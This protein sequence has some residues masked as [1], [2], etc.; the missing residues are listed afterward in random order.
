MELLNNDIKGKYGN[1]KLTEGNY[2]KELDGNFRIKDTLSKMKNF[3]IGLTT[4]SRW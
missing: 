1:N 4:E 2:K 3:L